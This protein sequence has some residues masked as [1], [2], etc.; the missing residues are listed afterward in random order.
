M[1]DEQFDETFDTNVKGAFFVA[2]RCAAIMR[3]GSAGGRIVNIASVAG[4]TALQGLTVY[5]MSKAAVVHMARRM[6]REWSGFGINV[7]VI[8]PGFVET[9]L[10]AGFFRTKAGDALKNRLPRKRIRDPSLL[11]GMLLTL[12]GD[13]AGAF[14]SGSIIPIDDGQLVA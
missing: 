13:R 8:C 11:H 10:N 4:L 6:A 12:L 9:E 2:E 3:Q 5:G 1:T 7:N 14:I